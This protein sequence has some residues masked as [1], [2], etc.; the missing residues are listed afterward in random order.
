MIVFSR[1][2]YACQCGTNVP[3]DDP[4]AGDVAR[5][6]VLSA[7]TEAD[8]PDLDLEHHDADHVAE[9]RSRLRA[10]E[11]WTVGRLD[12][13]IIHYHWISTQRRCTY[14]S[15][16]GCVFELDPRAAYGYDA[17]THPSLRGH[18]VRRRAFVHELNRVRALGREQEAGF[19]AAYHLEGAIRSL[20]RAGITLEPQWR[21]S[22]QRDRTLLF[23]QV[24]ERAPACWPAP[25]AGGRTVRRAPAAGAVAPG[26]RLW[27]PPQ[28]A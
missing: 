12:G 8:L 4:Q 25:E 2:V 27:E 6:V 26:N 5:R 23:E 3:A 15:L 9:L 17:W 18:G 24:T 10:G 7:G 13:Q 14:P 21:I 16:P 28:G 22:L 11:H 19:F 20:A 1:E